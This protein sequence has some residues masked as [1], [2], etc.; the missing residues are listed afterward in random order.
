MANGDDSCIV[1][2]AHQREV[3]QVA[4]EDDEHSLC[5]AQDEQLQAQTGQLPQF[6]GDDGHSYEQTQGEV[7]D[8]VN[9]F[10]QTVM[11]ARFES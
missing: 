10:V 6:H 3:Y 4:V 5:H 7:A 9:A 11:V 8:G 1:I 2:L